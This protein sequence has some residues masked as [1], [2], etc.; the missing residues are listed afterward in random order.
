M[1]E[2]EKT[3]RKHLRKSKPLVAHDLLVENLE[4]RKKLEEQEHAL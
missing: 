1:P 3:T 4:L 2:E